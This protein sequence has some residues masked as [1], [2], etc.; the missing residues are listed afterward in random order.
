VVAFI[1][2]ILAIFKDPKQSS[3]AVYQII[4]LLGATINDGLLETFA[5]VLAPRV[6]EKIQKVDCEFGEFVT[7]NLLNLFEDYVEERTR[8][9]ILRVLLRNCHREWFLPFF[10]ISL[11]LQM[12]A[13]NPSWP[14]AH[15]QKLNLAEVLD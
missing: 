9:E 10:V 2:S 7:R 11:F 5:H 3:I 6:F 4:T 1:Q 14:L 12:R 15:I 13:N 8:I